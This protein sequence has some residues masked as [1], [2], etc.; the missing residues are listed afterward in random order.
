MTADLVAKIGDLF[1]PIAIVVIRL[2]M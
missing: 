2:A 1:S